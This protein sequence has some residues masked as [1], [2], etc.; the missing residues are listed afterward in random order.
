MTLNLF[1]NRHIFPLV[2]G[3]WLGVGASAILAAGDRPETAPAKIT[4]SRI[5]IQGNSVLSDEEI[6]KLLRL[7]M[8]KKI[9]HTKLNEAW[10]R[11]RQGY[12]NQGHLEVHLSTALL[13]T[14]RHSIASVRIEEGP[15]YR[16]G[17]F[18]VEGNDEISPAHILREFELHEGDVFSPVKL[19]EGNKRLY[20]S[21]S[22]EMVTLVVSTAPSLVDVNVQVR[23]RNKQFVKGGAGYGTETKE[24]VSLGY[25]DQNFLGGARRFDVQYTASGFITQPEKY[26]THTVESTLTQPFLFGTR[27]VGQFALSRSRQFREAYDSVEREMRSGGERHYKSSLSLRL[28]H[29]LQGTDLTRVSPEAETPSETSVNAVGASL[30]FDNTDD[31]FLPR[32]GWRSYGALEEG[33]EMFKTDVGFHKVETRFGRFD[34]LD[35]GWTFFEGFQG[36]LIVP[37]SGG[38]AESIPINERFFLGGGN[39]VRGYAERSLGPKDAAGSP[40]GGTLYLVGNFEIRHVLYKKLFGVVFVDLG[41]LF[42]YAPGDD[43]AQVD[44]NGFDDL[45]QSGGVGFRFHSPVGAIRL[46]G[47]YQFNPEGSETFKD[48]TALHFSIGEVF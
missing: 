31:P 14:P 5:D 4:L 12:L 18:H 23:E 17:T 2:L 37:G 22:F 27:W 28:T 26:E 36:G 43:T 46:E 32:Q 40:L 42:S 19:L 35:S 34:T 47:G 39:S 41:N 10:E 21:G 48:R 8:G 38:S 15:L 11:L 16:M 24:R 29:R 9:K 45:R 3:L 44:L 6:R 33:L 25:E 13:P 30:R 1:K 7:K 20:A